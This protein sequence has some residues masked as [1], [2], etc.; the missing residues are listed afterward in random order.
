MQNN[1]STD[2]AIDSF[3]EMM[4]AER[5]AAGIRWNPIAAIWKPLRNLWQVAKP[6]WFQP[7]PSILKPALMR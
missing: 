7:I 5:G 1:L 4:S 2:A 6:D 3:L